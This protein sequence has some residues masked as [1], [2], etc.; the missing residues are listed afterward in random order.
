MAPAALLRAAG[1][2]GVVL[3]LAAGLLVYFVYHLTR[4]HIGA[5]FFGETARTVLVQ[6]MMRTVLPFIWQPIVQM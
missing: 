1:E 5:F 3:C 2:P 4:F 6:Q